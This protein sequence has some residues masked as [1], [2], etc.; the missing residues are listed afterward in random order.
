[1]PFR[2]FNIKLPV[3][4]IITPQTGFTYEARSLTV[5]EVNK[6]KTSLTTPARVH[7]VINQT[8]WDSLEQK[9]EFV[10]DYKDFLRFT[11]IKDRDAL[12][13]GLYHAT[14]GDEREFTVGCRSCENQKQMLKVSIGKL[15]KMNAYPHSSA[16]INSYKMV[17]NAGQIEVPDPEIEASI[18][19]EKIRKDTKK[20]PRGPATPIDIDKDDILTKPKDQ[21]KEVQ[22]IE[23]EVG[24]VTAPEP[25]QIFDENPESIL[26]RR[27]RVELPISKVLSIVRQPTLADEEYIMNNLAFAQKK[28]ADLVNDTLVIERFEQYNDKGQL[29]QVVADREDILMA[30]QELPPMDK[31]KIM[32]EYN[33]EFGQYGIELKAPWICNECSEENELMID[34][35]IQ[36]F[37]MAAIT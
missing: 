22:F 1:M 15:F 27:L 12:I 20:P 36:F 16:V 35:V 4:T 14:F 8:I 13:F 3:Y 6:L 10:K 5:A 33:K 37:R 25:I 11:T 26:N 24:N 34:I 23:K 21:K 31:I 29:D 18:E 2:G 28:Q 19:R 30:Y 7:N 9:P 32:E 17:K